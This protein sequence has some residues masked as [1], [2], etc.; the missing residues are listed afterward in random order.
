MSAPDHA[1]RVLPAGPVV[2]ICGLTRAEDVL[3]ARDLGAWA[4]GFV[5]APSPRRLEPAAA[6]GLIVEARTGATPEAALP[7]M[8]G[9]FGDTTA[10]EI[11]AIVEETGLDAVQLH[12]VAGPGAEAVRAALAGRSRP[13][14]VIQAV[15]VAPDLVDP[16]ALREAVRKAGEVADLALLDTGKGTRFGG[17]G[18]QF[19][20]PLGREVGKGL[21]FL[22]AGGIDPDNAGTALGESGAWGVDV[23]SGVESAPGAKDARLLRQLF[24]RVGASQA[25]DHRRQEGTHT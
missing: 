6:R 15:P 9:V 23:S 16:R 19:P 13:V 4:L 17:T 20:W 25:G 12:G 2:K 1:A 24:A 18:T 14:L 22:V 10:A 21:R 8:V 3:L 11:A 7:L 5:F